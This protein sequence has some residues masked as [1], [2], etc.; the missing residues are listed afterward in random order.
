MKQ[1]LHILQINNLPD[2][3]SY[4]N[5]KK[6]LKLNNNKQG[7]INIKG[8]EFF[9]KRN[10]IFSNNDKEELLYQYKWLVETKKI[11]EESVP[12]TNIFLKIGEIYGY[13]MEKINAN[14]LLEFLNLN[15]HK[16]VNDS[17]DIFNQIKI[18]I[19]KLH[20]KGIAHGDLDESNILINKK[21]QVIFIDPY[22]HNTFE[23][24]KKDDNE[25]LKMLEKILILE[26]R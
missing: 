5:I 25:R 12:K 21:N 18:K 23:E 17:L 15:K 22:K 2:G 26:K 19:N 11:L 10:D 16:S 4:D 3:I 13:I 1:K 6:E 14:T 24:T 20:N 8:N 9:F 7:P